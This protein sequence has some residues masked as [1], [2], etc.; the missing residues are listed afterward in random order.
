MKKKYYL[1]NKQIKLT[2][3]TYTPA[4]GA[5]GYI[6]NHFPSLLVDI[7]INSRNL[8]KNELLGTTFSIFGDLNKRVIGVSYIDKSDRN[9]DEDIFEVDFISKTLVPYYKGKYEKVNELYLKTHHTNKSYLR[10][11]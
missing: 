5:T 11:S 1:S 6:S 4:S 8:E 10:K 7:D 3:N 9:Y 2:Q